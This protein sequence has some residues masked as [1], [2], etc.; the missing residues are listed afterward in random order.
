MIRKWTRMGFAAVVL[1]FAASGACS[2]LPSVE[3]PWEIVDDPV[4]YSA[5][6][7]EAVLYLP[8]RSGKSCQGAPVRA[9]QST[10]LMKRRLSSA[11]RPGSP[12]LPES[13]GSIL[14]YSSSAMW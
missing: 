4:G 10:A 3:Q 7:L 11:F 1:L 5:A 2:A 13:S 6:A 8:Y 14:A 12:G 9:I